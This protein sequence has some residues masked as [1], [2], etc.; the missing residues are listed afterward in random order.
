MFYSVDFLTKNNGL[1]ICWIA[2]TLGSKTKKLSKKVINNVDIGAQVEFL[3]NPSE[4]LALRLSSHLLLG[5]ARIYKQ[6]YDFYSGDVQQVISRMQTLHK[7]KQIHSK[8]KV[9]IDF[10]QINSLEIEFQEQEL[11]WE[12]ESHLMGPE[13]LHLPAD[14]FDLESIKGLSLSTA[15]DLDLGVE[16]SS[17]DLGYGLGGTFNIDLD[18]P[19][20]P[21]PLNLN[22]SIPTLPDIEVESKKAVPR[23]RSNSSRRKAGVASF[24][25]FYDKEIDGIIKPEIFQ[26]F[27]FQSLIVKSCTPFIAKFNMEIETGRNTGSV[28]DYPLVPEGF[29]SF[30]HE[31]QEIGRALSSSLS[32]AG[33]IS[34][35]ALASDSTSKQKTPSKISRLLSSEMEMANRLTKKIDFDKYS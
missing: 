11:S 27:E 8:N 14:Q 22:H 2:S 9:E 7:R 35:P 25:K 4:P 24:R 33:E 21:T 16:H 28:D 15:G 31:S 10:N 6:Q 17:N 1:S 12:T 20:H 29:Q 13:S 19:S 3:I 18:M 32:V 23:K 30:S 26:W 34:V 5:I